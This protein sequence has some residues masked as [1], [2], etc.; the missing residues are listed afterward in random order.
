MKAE[1][2]NKE[3]RYVAPEMETL[4]ISIHGA[5]LESQME[6]VTC[7]PDEDQCWSVDE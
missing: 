3:E 5:L 2:F 1:N 6:P 4:Q 7:N